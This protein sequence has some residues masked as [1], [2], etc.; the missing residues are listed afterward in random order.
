MGWSTLLQAEYEFNV[1]QFPSL[2]HPLL[3]AALPTFVM[4]LA[5]RLSPRPW[6]A[7][8]VT[9]A[10]SLLRVL[11]AGFLMGTSSLGL[12]G[13]TRP[14]IPLLLLSAVA[15]DLLAKRGAAP[16]LVGLVAGG[17]TLLG[18]WLLVSLGDGIAWY[19]EVMALAALPALALAAL[20]G[21]AGSAVAEALK[22]REAAA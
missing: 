4:A 18:N 14:M 21:W 17:I 12:A 11:L 1:P 8:L 20:A 22:D 13:D 2:F 6:S 9:L 15:V 5:S 7:T 19:G 16:W 10:F 3:L